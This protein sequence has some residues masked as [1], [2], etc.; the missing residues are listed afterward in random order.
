MKCLLEKLC[1]VAVITEVKRHG[2]FQRIQFPLLVHSQRREKPRVER[3][4]QGVQILF[5]VAISLSLVRPTAPTAVSTRCPHP[6]HTLLPEISSDSANQ[7]PTKSQGYSFWVRRE[8]LFI[9]RKLL[10][11]DRAGS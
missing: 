2:L 5:E 1:L 7:V 10:P 9:G 8:H 3:L 11:T 4:N 6:L